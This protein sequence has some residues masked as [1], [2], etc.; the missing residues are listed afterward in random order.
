MNIENVLRYLLPNPG[1]YGRLLTPDDYDKIEWR[2]TRPKPTWKELEAGEAQMLAAETAHT[3]EIKAE[4]N[5]IDTLRQEYALSSLKALKIT[6][7]QERVKTQLEEPD[8][9][10]KAIEQL[11]I[12]VALLARRVYGNL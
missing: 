6:Q 5:D 3:A 8:G 1:F 4:R 9:M 2:D 12:A 7:L 11:A 10:K